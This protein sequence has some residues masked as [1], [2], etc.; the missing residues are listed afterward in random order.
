[1]VP[2]IITTMLAYQTL[3]GR[4]ARCFPLLHHRR[5]ERPNPGPAQEE[6]REAPQ[7]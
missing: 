2:V 3:M 4:A 1:M 6:E 5:L 7:Q